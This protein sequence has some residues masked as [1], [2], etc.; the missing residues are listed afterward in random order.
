M[1]RVLTLLCW[2]VLGLG[3]SSDGRELGLQSPQLP[4]GLEDL[5]Q[6][7]VTFSLQPGSR[8]AIRHACGGGSGQPADCQLPQGPAG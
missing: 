2:A 7:V 4:A 6:V 5:D 3:S 1:H 8:E